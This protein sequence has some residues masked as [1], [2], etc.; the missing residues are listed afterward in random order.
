MRSHDNNTGNTL[1]YDKPPHKLSPAKTHTLTW[2]YQVSFRS[3][4]DK[5]LEKLKTVALLFS[6]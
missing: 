3:C 6:L 5:E 4:G 1:H 2:F